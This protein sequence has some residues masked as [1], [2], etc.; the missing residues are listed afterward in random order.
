MISV[1]HPSRGRGDEA[2]N[3]TVNWISKSSTNIEYT[4]VIDSDDLDSYNPGMN[5]FIRWSNSSGAQNLSIMHNN[6]KSAIEAINYGASNSYGDIL[7]VISDDFDCPEHWDTLLLE[8]IGNKTDFCAKTSDGHQDWLI[9]LPIMDRKYYERFGYVY[10]P[11][12]QHMFADLEMTSV[13][14]M[15]GRYIELPLTFKHNHYSV[16][17]QQPDAINRKNNATWGH[18]QMMFKKRMAQNFG[19]DPVQGLP[20]LKKH[21]V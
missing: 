7:I 10:N 18:G 5:D 21:F 2:Y 14:W 17:G 16:T 15:L 20:D 6:N 1:I 19:I 8:A 9:T 3:T 13:A 11:D 4:M 12:Y